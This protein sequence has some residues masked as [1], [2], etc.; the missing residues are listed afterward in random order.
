MGTIQILTIVIPVR[1]RTTQISAQ[2]ICIRVVI[3]K[4]TADKLRRYSVGS[5]VDLIHS[6]IRGHYSGREIEITGGN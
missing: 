6:E 3:D 1:D 5:P 2:P 4:P